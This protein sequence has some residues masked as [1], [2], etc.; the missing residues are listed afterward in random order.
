MMG[1][2]YAAYC[3]SERSVLSSLWF[4][5]PDADAGMGGGADEMAELD[6]WG[7]GGRGSGTGGA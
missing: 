1:L 6:V 3:A 5:S 2:R 7:G 4:I